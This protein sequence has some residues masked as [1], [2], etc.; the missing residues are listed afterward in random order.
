MACI[1]VL[2]HVDILG[3]LANQ[4]QKRF[5]HEIFCT[6]IHYITEGEM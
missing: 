1:S 5:L 4:L 2:E 3:Y 6:D